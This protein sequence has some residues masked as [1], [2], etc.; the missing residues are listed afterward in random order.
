MSRTAL[1]L[2]LALLGRVAFEPMAGWSQ[3]PAGG[4]TIPNHAP[5]ALR[6]IEKK[7][8]HIFGRVISF[9]GEP[10]GEA[11]VRVDIG[12]GS[13]GVQTL[14]TN[15]QGEFRTE[16]SLDASQ[17]KKLTVHVTASKPG[18][19]EARETAEFGSS[20]T[21]EIDLVLRERAEDPDQLSLSGLVSAL[22]P[23]LRASAAAGL[24][25]S[26]SRKD[27]DRGAR[28]FLDRRDAVR[29]LPL[30]TRV[31]QREPGCVE[32]RTL[33]GLAL[34]EAGSWTGG[35][36]QLATAAG[37][38]SAGAVAAK[39][40]GPLLVLG[41]LESWRHQ[42]KKA[43]GLF[44][45]ALQLEPANPLILQELGR[46]LVFQQNW[47][48]AEQY[49]AE[50][51]KAG[52]G[53]EAHLLRARALLE[54]GATDEAE[55]EM[56]AYLGHRRV[57]DLPAPA[58]PI[59]SELQ[60][61]LELKSYGKVKSVIAQPIGELVRAVPELK[62]LEPAHSQEQL[63]LILQKVGES[64]L[65]FFH[66]FPDTISV[67][68]IR[69][70]RLSRDGKVRETLDQDFRYLLLARPEKWGLGLEEY[71]T[72]S[73]G[74]PTAPHGLEG[75]FMLTAGFASASVPFHPAYQSDA[76]FC[77]LGRQVVDGRET[78]VV[79][80]AQLPEKARA[81]ERFN[82]DDKSA[83]ILLQ[84]IAWTDATGYYVVRMRTDLLAPLSQVRL[85]KQTT[86][87]RFREVRFKEV[88]SLLWLPGEVAVTVE[89]KGK[90][91]RNLHR[92]SD[93]KLFNVQTEEKR[94][95]AEL[96]SPTPPS[97]AQD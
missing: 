65:A 67:E 21:W 22:G 78:H 54:E 4:P 26:S 39:K 10:V 14:E 34:L 25:S 49:L 92:Y 3:I 19:F 70:Q 89:W 66:N 48:P 5:L 60:D 37:L 81:V 93:F 76:T 12:T 27:Y 36:Q 32:C 96:A 2:F 84:G 53:K 63:P 13:S 38:G 74:A 29:A 62:G 91:Y 73:R 42:D 6:N 24:K 18:Y 16:Y 56:K 9:R 31:A 46:T 94:K 35:S 1:L 68:Q 15:P 44:L 43:A 77:L 23:K 86:E 75:G 20:K 52:A 58:R 41:V 83:L 30:L 33:L 61:R 72:D 7:D 71:R 88:R 28:E 47:E 8:W 17:Y 80:F 50:A 11:S 95:A 97:P 40:P 79:G 69:Q 59:Y 87:I 55:A 90:T 82:A 51:I 85:E 57:K 64:V 45:E